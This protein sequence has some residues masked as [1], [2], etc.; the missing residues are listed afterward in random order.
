[1]VVPLINVRHGA[2]T[3]KFLQA[4]VVIGPNEQASSGKFKHVKQPPVLVNPLVPIT[5]KHGA[6][7]QVNVVEELDIPLTQ[8]NLGK[9]KF[10]IAIEVLLMVKVPPIKDKL[11]TSIHILQAPE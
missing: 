3:F 10:L 7:R 6:L 9:H 2:L 4:F 5:L 1:V 8:S 11:E